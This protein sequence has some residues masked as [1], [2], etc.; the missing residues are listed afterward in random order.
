M[1]QISGGIPTNWKW[2]KLARIKN[3]RNCENKY[4]NGNKNQ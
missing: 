3:V 1:P 2:K 4:Y